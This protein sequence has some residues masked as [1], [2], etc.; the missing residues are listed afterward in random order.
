MLKKCDLMLLIKG[1]AL[2]YI[3]EVKDNLIW[4]L[5]SDDALEEH[6]SQIEEITQK[7]TNCEDFKEII[8]ILNEANKATPLSLD[9]FIRIAKEAKMAV[10]LAPMHSL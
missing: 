7:I 2:N 9:K 5:S 1:A 6:N 10:D 8:F 3:S 4:P